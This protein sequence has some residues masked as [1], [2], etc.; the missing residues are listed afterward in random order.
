VTQ[1]T[2]TP[3]DHVV[4]A[5]QLKTAVSSHFN[6]P[7]STGIEIVAEFSLVIRIMSGGKV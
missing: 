3:T 6:H 4:T 5:K 2:I 7:T 1:N